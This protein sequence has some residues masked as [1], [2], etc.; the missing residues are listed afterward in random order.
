MGDI[1]LIAY[2]SIAVYQAIVMF[3]VARDEG[4]LHNIFSGLIWPYG[5]Y[6]A[7]T[8]DDDDE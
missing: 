6:V 8:S 3:A 1:F 7:Y 4:V 5:L 2:F